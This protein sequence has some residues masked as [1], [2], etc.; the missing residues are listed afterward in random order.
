MGT[1]NSAAATPSSLDGFY[2]GDKVLA[3]S[4]TAPAWRP[5]RIVAITPE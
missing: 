5:A 1:T 3:L 4:M 2:E